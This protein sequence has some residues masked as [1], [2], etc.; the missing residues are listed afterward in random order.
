MFRT[1]NLSPVNLICKVQKTFIKKM[2]GEDES[3]T[4]KAKIDLARLSPCKNY[5]ILHIGR[6]NIGRVNIGRVTC[7][8][9][10]TNTPQAI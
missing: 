5:I 9:E 10:T 6:V 4:I 2:A 7:H 3:L 8:I 1:P